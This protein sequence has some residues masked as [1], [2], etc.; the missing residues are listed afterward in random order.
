MKPFS[1]AITMHLRGLQALR[2]KPT[3]N[4]GFFRVGEGLSETFPG[5]ENGGIVSNT[6]SRTLGTAPPVSQTLAQNAA[7]LFTAVTPGLQQVSTWVSP[8]T[9]PAP[10]PT[11]AAAPQV[12]QV[13]TPTTRASEI[14]P[15]SRP[16]SGASAYKPPAPAPAPLQPVP[17]GAA[18]LTS[19]W[20]FSGLQTAGIGAGILALGTAAVLGVKH[21]VKGKK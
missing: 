2:R 12:Q 17:G 21:F 6:Q 19:K 5:Q 20:P 4:S 14:G 15:G 13:T 7:D 10:A 8:P 9:P 16:P 18:M 3:K 11:P 1:G